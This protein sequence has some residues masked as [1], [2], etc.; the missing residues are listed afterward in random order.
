MCERIKQ[1]EESAEFDG[2]LIAKL[3]IDAG[4]VVGKDK[5][6]IE[7]ESQLSDAMEL[8]KALE[9]GQ[10]TIMKRFKEADNKRD[11]AVRALIEIYSLDSVRQ[12]EC[13][14]IAKNTLDDI[15]PDFGD[16]HV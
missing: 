6:I 12:D 7:L 8:I 1:L 4:Q 13:S 2:A 3:Q 9:A 14:G 10:N 16:H 5:L 11:L 15:D